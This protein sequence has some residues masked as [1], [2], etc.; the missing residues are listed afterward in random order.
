MAKNNQTKLLKDLVRRKD[1]GLTALYTT[2]FAAMINVV[3]GT[4]YPDYNSGWSFTDILFNVGAIDVTIAF[5]VVFISA[6]V[7]FGSDRLVELAEGNV[8]ISDTEFLSYVGAVGIPILHTS[9]GA[10]ADISAN[11]PLIQ[12]VFLITGVFSM[13]YIAKTP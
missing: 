1:I 11:D 4:V 10:F 5:A 6:T 9:W 7:A 12:T 8:E 13:V 3:S 2:F